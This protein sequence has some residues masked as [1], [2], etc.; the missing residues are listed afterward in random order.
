MAGAMKN[1]NGEELPK[2]WRQIGCDENG[3]AT[4]VI[5]PW[6]QNCRID[7]VYGFS[8]CDCGESVPVGI[9]KEYI[10]QPVDKSR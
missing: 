10:T 2:G 6:C 9:V 1:S 5:E 4:N 3:E 8:Y 7:L